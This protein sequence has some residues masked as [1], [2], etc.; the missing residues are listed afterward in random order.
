VIFKRYMLF[1]SVH[2]AVLYEFK[3]LKLILLHIIDHD[4]N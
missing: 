4:D 2:L 1:K 3:N